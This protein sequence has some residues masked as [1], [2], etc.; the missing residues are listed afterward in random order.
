[1]SLKSN[2]SNPAPGGL[3]VSL[4]R[5]LLVLIAVTVL[6]AVGYR[7]LPEVNTQ[8]AQ[9]LQLAALKGEIDHQKQLLA[10]RVREESLLKRDAEY[11]GIIARDQLDVMKPNETI[12]R[13]ELSRPELSRMKRNP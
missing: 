3:W 8:K 7:Y 9:E 11:I 1:M 2:Y 4:N 5:L 6:T 12:Y 13:V 10:R